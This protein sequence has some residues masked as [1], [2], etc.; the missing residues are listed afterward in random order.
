LQLDP[1]AHAGIRLRRGGP[2]FASNSVARMAADSVT[3]N[4]YEMT[5]LES[6]GRARA[7]RVRPRLGDV[8]EGYV[9]A[10]LL[11]LGYEANLAPAGKREVDIVV[12]RPDFRVQVKSASSPS[13]AVGKATGVVWGDDLFYVLV[14]FDRAMNTVVRTLVMPS[15][16]LYS[17]TEEQ[18][19]EWRRTRR[20][21]VAMKPW[22]RTLKEF[23]PKPLASATHLL[24]N[25]ANSWDRLP[26]T[27][28]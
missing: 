6:D 19:N 2:E 14:Q 15:H 22:P 8:G 11:E 24:A 23:P 25:Y 17:I 13:W 21:T 5:V 1:V 9:L 10:R 3:V 16:D 18:T 26:S 27:S 20:P 12:S 7:I 28:D 4:T